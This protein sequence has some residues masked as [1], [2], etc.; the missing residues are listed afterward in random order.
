MADTVR[1]KIIQAVLSKLAIIMV[2]NGFNTEIGGNVERGKT[3]DDPENVPKLSLWAGREEAGK[4]IGAHVCNMN[5]RLEAL[6]AVGSEEPSV[7]AEKAL[8]DMIRAMCGGWGGQS[9]LA[10]T[11]GGYG[12]EIVY[13]SGGVESWPEPEQKVLGVPAEFIIKYRIKIGDPYNQP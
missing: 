7:L 9:A 1:K 10:T 2:A 8:G 3:H 5:L 12:D 11:T 13:Q 4:I 6:L